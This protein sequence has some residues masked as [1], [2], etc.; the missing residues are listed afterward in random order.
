MPLAGFE[1]TI[2]VIERAKTVH[3]LDC[4]ATVIGTFCKYL[5]N[6]KFR[7]FSRIH[8]DPFNCLMLI[9]TGYSSL[10]FRIPVYGSDGLVGCLRREWVYW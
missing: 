6:V 5:Q 1:P 3:A 8:L 2:P 9:E 7:Y 4:A 10:I